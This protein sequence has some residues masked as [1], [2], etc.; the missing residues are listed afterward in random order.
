MW[1]LIY[2]MLYLLVAVAVIVVTAEWIIKDSID[3]Y[4][5]KKEEQEQVHQNRKRENCL[6]SDKL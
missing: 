1:Q 6:D 4:F 5:K 2:L 3:Y